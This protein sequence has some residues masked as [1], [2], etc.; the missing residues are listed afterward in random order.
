MENDADAAALAEATWGSGVG[1]DRFLY[2]TLSTGIGTG[3][4]VQGQ[5]YRGV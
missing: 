4:L 2:V 5:V 1:V 3:F